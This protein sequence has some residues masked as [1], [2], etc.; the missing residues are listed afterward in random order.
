MK[1]TLSA[2]LTLLLTA[3]LFIFVTNTT[4]QV[5]EADAVVSIP[6][7]NLAAAIRDALGLPSGAALTSHAMLKLTRLGASGRGIA[8]LTGLEYAINLTK[9]RLGQ[10]WG[11]GESFTNPISDLSALA[12]LTQLTHLELDGTAV[13]DVAPLANLTQLKTLW[14]EG[15][16]VSDVAPLAH[17]TQLKT[18]QLHSTAV[19]DVAPL[20]HLTQLTTLS[21]SWTAVSDVAPLA[22]LT[23]LTFLDL[24]DT[25]VSDVAPLAHLTQLKTLNL[26][27]T[28]VSDVAPLA[29]LTQL[30]WLSLYNTAISDVTPLAH[31][32]Q[33]TTLTL[34]NTAVSDVAPLA[35]LTQ[36]TTLR[37]DNTAVSDVAPLENLTQLTE[38]KLRNCPLNAAAHQTHIPAIQANGTEVHFDP[39]PPEEVIDFPDAN[40]AAAIRGALG[41]PAGAPITTHSILGLVTLDAPNAGIKDL[42]GLA[43]ATNLTT[44]LLGSE[45][46]NGTEVNSNTLAE[47]APIAQ[48]KALTTLDLSGTAVSS[49]YSLGS[50]TQ[51]TSLNLSDTA[52]SD[53]SYLPNL[54]QLTFLNL[55]ETGIVDVSV[56]VN[57][58]GLLLL[59]LQ[60]AP[61]NLAAHQTHIPAMQVNGVTVLFDPLPPE[62]VVDFPDANL[63]AAI[64]DALGLPSGAAITTDSILGLVTLEAPNRGIKDL[65]GL[66]HAVNLTELD[67]GSEYVGGW[68][69]WVN[70]NAISDW[71]PLAKL[72]KLTTLDLA[73]TSVS[74]VAPLANLTQLTWLSLAYT[75]VSDVAPLA[76]LTQLTWLSLAYTAVSD[77]APLANLTQLTYLQLSNTAVSDVAPLA[78]LTQL[79]TLYL[80]HTAVSDVAPLANLTQLT[81][82][83]L[84]HTAV[85]DVAPLAN[86]TQL[87]TLYL[88][89]TA[90]SDVTPL[91]PLTQ[92]TRLRLDDC[93]LN[94]AAHQTHIPAIQANGTEVSFDPFKPIYLPRGP[95]L[96]SLIYFRPSDRPVRPNVDAEI[97][98]LIK[99][100]QR[101]FADQLE[102]HGFER[103]TFQ[104]ETDARGNAVVHH[105]T[106]KFP[107][108]HYPQNRYSWVDEINEQIH[109]PPRSF[110]VHMLDSAGGRSFTGA[111]GTGGPR[112]S[113]GKADID[114]WH[115]S[116][117][118][119]ELAHAF[120]LSHDYRANAKRIRTLTSDAMLT[121]FCAAEWLNVHP[122][123]NPGQA[124][125]TRPTT[126]E[127]LPPTLIS[128]PNTIRLRFEVTHPEGLH[129]Q[130]QLQIPDFYAYSGQYF[131]LIDCQ[132]LN[133]DHSTVEFVTTEL[134]PQIEEVRLSVINVPGNMSRASFPIDVTSLI[135]PAKPVS[136]PDANLAAAVR[137]TL[138][139]SSGEAITTHAML[140]LDSLT[141]RN[142]GIKDL[143]GLE[144]AVGLRSLT[145]GGN[146]IS[147]EGFVN[148]NAISDWSPIA[149]LAELKF[150]N[151]SF[152]HG[153]V[154]VAPLA[155]LTQLTW[156]VLHGTAVSDVAP[157]AN[158][159]Q[160][161]WLVLSSTAVADVAPL[162]NLTQLSDL[163]LDGTAVSD[164]APLA[165]L[166]QLGILS[167]VSTRVSDISPLAS[168][169]Q[170]RHLSIDGTRVSDVSAL[171]PLTRLETLSIENTN[172]SDVS[173]LAALTQLWLLDLGHTGVSDV[174]ALANITNLESLYLHGTA[175]SDVA[176]LA[177]LTQL[178]SLYLF[179]TAVSD[180]APL[181]NLT[182]LRHL[183]LDNTAV[184]DV[185]PL[186]GLDL[187]GTSRSSRTLIGLRLTGC[188]L[189]YASIHTHIP[190]LQAKGIE[191]EF[192]N[193]AHP[194]LLKISGDEQEGAGGTALK[195]PFVV[196]AMDE[197][198]KPIVGKPVQFEILEGGGT[199][200]AQTATTDARG[201][202]QITLTL[203][204]AAGVNKVKATAEGIES[205]VLFT[206]VATEAAPQ[207][208]ADVNGDG[209][210][211]ILDLTTVSGQFG[212][213]GKNNA[214]VNGDGQVN[215]QDLVLVAGA[216]GQ[217]AAAPSARAVSLAR[218]TAADLEQWL[219]EARSASRPGGLSYRRGIVVLEQLRANLIPEET[220]L[221]ANYPNPFNPETWIP[222][223][224]ATPAEV[225][226]T[227]YAATGAVVRTLALGHR[228]AG[229]YASRP[230][231]A[232]WDG[233]NALGER[234][235][236]GVY[237][238]TLQA[239]DFA[240]TRKMLILK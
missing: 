235:A 37:L 55:G 101:F 218:L 232:Y 138:G 181:A 159:T 113:G 187:Q 73:Y 12:A 122:A 140:R 5:E 120:G 88:H 132:R 220:A 1:K 118:A 147:G 151:L 164:V 228:R 165:N 170:L 64:R 124:A 23:Q 144:H 188:P 71:S 179:N 223:Q 82:L 176:P 234:V 190:A 172:V 48:L 84:Y 91:A 204:R 233:R 51:L 177:N 28:A 143:T 11:D 27:Y 49:T 26:S 52:V 226:V 125:P 149:R 10:A 89:H 135:P 189:S 158:L 219:S 25:A 80:H 22:N 40:L 191:V 56:L 34:D 186:V 210:V 104:F 202:A 8:D 111:A 215:I 178:E 97:D 160:L 39:L 200:S 106:G 72:A 192:D 167:L 24:Y 239:G 230:R 209:I 93:P 78:N 116:T 236:S 194:A 2:V 9:L 163:S 90:V 18:L 19:S 153:L 96:V 237:F 224:L 70:S 65:T 205:W 36:L 240:A 98:G 126:I 127:M 195:N 107:R 128:P 142:A 54:T 141:A 59:N 114:S 227:I 139:L 74:D 50:L 119:H 99:E 29:H 41:L 175:V 145:L 15:T 155:N 33:L 207:L 79:T 38:L 35:H 196:E 148:S 77:V 136:L 131:R 46:V 66:E 203:G 63:A 173:P 53:I 229:D 57:L 134:T 184:A 121:S 180:V 137:E 152:T 69:G 130:A 217:E 3:T 157:L 32:T 161:T 13:S 225:T 45:S 115:W 44:L 112:G 221:L 62:E 129:H 21:L 30:T 4:A 58:T 86:L 150:L 206:A 168:L 109:V 68:E 213:A 17:L 183:S 92:L 47:L 87:T 14:L 117:L 105:V 156:L 103:K 81:E 208:A 31:L 75:A 231:A 212:K 222:Y 193:V 102:L 162:A 171:V 201:K 146:Y 7:A 216:F 42:T 20:A 94:A 16:A 214:D 95:W 60:G 198:G 174:S 6:D 133:G 85:S 76:N 61:L 123:F 185:S 211:N 238:Y 110:T 182:Q 67:L 83:Y 43:Y 169:T 108:A 154:D 197:H 166:T 199:L 100:A